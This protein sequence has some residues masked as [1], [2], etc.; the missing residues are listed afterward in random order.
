[1]NILQFLKEDSFKPQLESRDK[2]G[3]IE[4]LVSL[5]S[6]TKKV[7]NRKALLEA[8]IKREELESTG[9]GEGVA[10]P[11]ARTDAVRDVAIAFGLSKEG[12]EFDSVDR[13]PANF[14]FLVVAPKEKDTEYIKLLASVARLLSRGDFRKKAKK[15]SS[16]KEMIELMKNYE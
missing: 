11:H 10:V 13:K 6:D 2:I 8:I 7:K 9:I 4:E 15:V 12:V 14:V 16:Y 3:V 1:M 5:L